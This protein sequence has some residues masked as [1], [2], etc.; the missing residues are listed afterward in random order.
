VQL[1]ESEET[2]ARKKTQE[3]WDVISVRSNPLEE[4]AGVFNKRSLRTARIGLAVAVS[5]VVLGGVVELVF[6]VAL[7][8][9][10]FT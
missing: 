8:W 9:K 5:L 1:R 7:F 10:I 2:E 4:C 6:L 3:L